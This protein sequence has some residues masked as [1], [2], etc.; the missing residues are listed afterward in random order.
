MVVIALATATGILG[1]NMPYISHK[2]VPRVNNEYI[3]NEMPEVSLVLMVLIACGKNE[4]VV[5]NA[6]IKPIISM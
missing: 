1:L 4:K 2:T 6:A 5:P 3:Y